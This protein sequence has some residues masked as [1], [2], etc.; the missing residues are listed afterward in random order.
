MIVVASIIIVSFALAIL[1]F[2][3]RQHVKGQLEIADIMHEIRS[4]ER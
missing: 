1:V 3:R 2:I 4:K